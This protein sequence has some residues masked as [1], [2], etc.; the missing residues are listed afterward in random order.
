MTS[1]KS[2]TSRLVCVCVCVWRLIG[3][4][5]PEIWWPFMMRQ[6]F[7]RKCKQTSRKRLLLCCY[8]CWCCLIFC[9][10]TLWSH[11]GMTMPYE[12][13]RMFQSRH[14]GVF[15]MEQFDGKLDRPA[16]DLGRSLRTHSPQFFCCGSDGTR[17]PWI[18]YIALSTRKWINVRWGP[19]LSGSI[20]FSRLYYTK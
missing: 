15:S 7:N 20:T 17:S 1:Y 11:L 12:S 4:F 16:E 2:Y 5:S 9:Y 10:G 3:K 6:E 8:C 18:H 19:I 13:L 14:T